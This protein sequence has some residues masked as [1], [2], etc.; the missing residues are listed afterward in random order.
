MVDKIVLNKEAS[1]TFEKIKKLIS[2]GAVKSREREIKVEEINKK[3][4]SI[5]KQ[6]SLLI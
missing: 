5:N 4:R 2:D 6:I 3:I 1:K